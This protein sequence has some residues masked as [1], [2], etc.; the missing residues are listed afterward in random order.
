MTSIAR[1]P[2]SVVIPCFCCEDTI[3]RA[4]ASVTRQTLL[5]IEII[6]VDDA[7]HDN[8]SQVLKRLAQEG[9]G[10]IHVVTHKNNVGAAS[11]RNLGW[12]TA[13]QPYIAFL[14]ADDAWHPA[15]IELQ[16]GY[17]AAHPE[18]VLSGHTHRILDR[19][20]DVPDWAVDRSE[21]F[22]VSATAMLFSNRFITPSVMLK[23][24]IPFRFAD[25]RRH[26]E[27][28]LLW[29]EV[30]CSGLKVVR[31]NSALAATYKP[32]YG[33][34]GLSAQLWLME[35]GDLQ[36]YRILFEKRKIGF[37]AWLA[38]SAFS[39]AKYGRR[40]IVTWGYTRWKR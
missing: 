19:Y 35:R 27:D 6:L 12:D 10:L 3:Q 2:V 7:S 29:M 15:K 20:S 32:M 24:E 18:V 16:Y 36:N 17:M 23:R 11:A 14:D 26:M 31:L 33:T 28:H 40:L 5:P 1:A 38:F 13:T 25:G 8:T 30:A 37:A 22:P 34:S 39:L 9:H 4:I 21:V